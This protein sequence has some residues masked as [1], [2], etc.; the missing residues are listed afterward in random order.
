MSQP[1]PVQ[2]VRSTSWSLWVPVALL[3]IVVGGG[4]GW[5]WN[6]HRQKAKA[7]ADPV[8]SFQP[9]V[10]GK[11]T[12]PAPAPP[13]MAWIAGGRFWMGCDDPRMPDALPFHPVELDGFWM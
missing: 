1:L 6:S 10:D 12:A 7:A 4:G 3:A 11:S 8:G 9:V 5:V 2:P 13:G